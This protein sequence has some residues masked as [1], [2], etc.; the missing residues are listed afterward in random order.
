MNH[1]INHLAVCLLVIV[2]QAIGAFWYSTMMFVNPW[3]KYHEKTM[4]DGDASDPSPFIVAIVAAIV[5]NYSL[6]WLFSR[7]SIASALAGLKLA[8]ICWFAFLFVEYAT[9]TS[10]SAFGR[11]PWNLVF[12]DMGR[13][14]CV[15]ALAG[16]LLGAW[17][18]RPANA[19]AS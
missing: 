11:N 18:R 17:R 5:T 16:L 14:F 19:L 9:I 7:M 1:R 8:L 13:A 10:F 3:L 2:D 4:A 15:F 12:I 6:A